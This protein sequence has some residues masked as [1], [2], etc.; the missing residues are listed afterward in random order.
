MLTLSHEADASADHYQVYSDRVR[1]GTIYRTSRN[2][3]G[4]EWM[5]FLN[6]VQNGV[7]YGSGFALSL[8]DAK[9]EFARAWGAWLKA[10]GLAENS[11]TPQL[12]RL[13]F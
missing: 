7:A 5:W 9:T 10:A 6:G 2:A 8:D 13:G 4:K 3:E 1:I 11:P 12:Q